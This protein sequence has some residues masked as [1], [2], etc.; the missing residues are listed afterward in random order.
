MTE[1]PN[2]GK[3]IVGQVLASEEINPTDQ[4]CES[5]NQG[6]DEES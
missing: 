4:D 3:A 6:C 5:H 2:G 1:F